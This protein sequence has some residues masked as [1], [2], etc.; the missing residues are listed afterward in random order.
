MKEEERGQIRKRTDKE[1]ELEEKER[2]KRKRT[3][4]GRGDGE[5]REGEIKKGRRGRVKDKGED[6]REKGQ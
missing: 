3:R 5:G 4:W 1:E 6:G 2:K